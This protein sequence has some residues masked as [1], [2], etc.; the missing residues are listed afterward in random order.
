M[1]NAEIC[2]AVQ[3]LSAE[4]WRRV[5]RLSAA[6]VSELY[7]ETGALKI[8]ALQWNGREE[9]DRFFAER[10]LNELKTERTTRHITGG[11]AVQALSASRYQVFSTVQVLSG[12]GPLPLPSQAPSSVAD[13]IDVVVQTAAGEWRYES[14]TAHAVFTGAGAPAFAR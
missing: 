8:N 5:D 12:N 2:C 10:N 4:Y 14:R 11:L 6:P 13:F 7:T 1:V 3:W 9:I